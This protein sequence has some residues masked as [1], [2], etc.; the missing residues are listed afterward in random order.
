MKKMNGQL[1]ENR[2]AIEKQSRERKE[3]L[4][5][6]CHD[7]ANPLSS[8]IGVMDLIEVMPQ[9]T[10]LKDEA[11]KVAYKGL[12]IIELV[13]EMRAI[14]DNK[15][16]LKLENINLKES[17]TES[18]M[19]LRKKFEN[20]NITPDVDIPGDIIISAEKIS[21]VNSVINNLLTNALKFSNEGSVIKINVENNSAGF[22][23][24][25]VSD[26]GVGMSP[27]L[28]KDIFN[29]N[30][31]TNRTGT[32]GEAGTGFGMPL[33]KKFMNAYGGEITVE[34][35]AREQFPGE[36]GTKVKLFFK[37]GQDGG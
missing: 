19:I 4:H 29:A 17:V 15:A 2:N 10:T 6:L 18:L 9:Y 31:A 7:L 5:V 22:I 28:Q 1:E 21:L 8:I 26:T 37:P 36:H 23:C 33:V 25:A 34:S 27:R 35:K 16:T 20:K 14:E 11:V 30:K 12:D 13:R 32:A 24:L 3:L